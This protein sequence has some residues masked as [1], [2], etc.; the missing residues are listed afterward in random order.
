MDFNHSTFCGY[1]ACHWTEVI[2]TKVLVCELTEPKMNTFDSTLWTVWCQVKV[3]SEQMN[4]K[5]TFPK[6]VDSLTH[7]CHTFA[8]L[9]EVESYICV[10]NIQ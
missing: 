7:N 6:I 3:S 2:S 9:V 8:N 4:R 5:G 1:F 10:F